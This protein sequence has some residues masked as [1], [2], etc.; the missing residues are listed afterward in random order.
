M[1]DSSVVSISASG[2]RTHTSSIDHG[3][4]T[5]TFKSG[6]IAKLEASRVSDDARR[7]MQIK[8]DQTI[9]LDFINRTIEFRNSNDKHGSRSELSPTNPL[10]DELKNFAD[11][12]LSSSLPKVTGAMAANA[13]ELAFEIEQ[14][15]KSTL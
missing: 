11:C 3:L 6:S 13:L 8:G 4:E 10:R 14:I 1:I 12:I 15:I 2:S 9:S 7:Q 5:I